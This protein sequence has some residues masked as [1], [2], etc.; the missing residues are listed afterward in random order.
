MKFFF[1]LSGENNTLPIGELKA[2]LELY[3]C[4]ST[5][6]KI[7]NRLFIVEGRI[8]PN[9]IV[10]RGAH[11]L[12][13]GMLITYCKK[14]DMFRIL[15]S[16]R[17]EEFINKSTIFSALVFNLSNKDISKNF[18][19]II[20]SAV[21][22]KVPD[23]K[24]SLKN[25]NKTI[26]AIITNEKVIF[27]ITDHKKKKGWHSRRPRIRPF[28]HPSVLYP[29]FARTLVN[30]SRIKENETL[31]DPFCGTGSVLIE[32]SLIGANMIGIDLSI[33]M[34][35][36]TL[37]NLKYYQLETLGIIN[38]DSTKL[39]L[40]NIDAIVTDIPYG[41][42]TSINMEITN[43]LSNFINH[44]KYILAKN[45]Y[46]VIVHPLTVRLDV[47]DGFELKEKYEIFVH[48]SLTRVITILKRI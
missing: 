29:K 40:K 13:G 25:P 19:S 23:A 26:M 17:F 24:V 42:S 41:K 7:T 27:G 33:K 16:L 15:N 21:K 32:T 35:Q 18:E 1:L 31:L 22:S 45:K 12:F 34:C 39:A 44:V 5:F 46:C 36:G 48:R 30:L 10:Q 38:S 8:D 28:F 14:E 47:M 3:D 43:L 20:G 2:L 37:N 11:V 6:Q 9:L 4:N